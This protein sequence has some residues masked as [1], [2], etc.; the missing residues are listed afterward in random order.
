[1]LCAVLGIALALTA[2]EASEPVSRVSA[3]VEKQDGSALEKH[4]IWLIRGEGAPF[5]VDPDTYEVQNPNGRTD[6]DG[7]VTIEVP[8]GLFENGEPLSLAWEKKAGKKSHFTALHWESGE[9]LRF[10][11]EEAGD[12]TNLGT[13]IAPAPRE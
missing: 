11:L 4:W 13:L 8:P 7:R 9:R 1:M 2:G 6:G 12:A 5:Q 10:T 3:R